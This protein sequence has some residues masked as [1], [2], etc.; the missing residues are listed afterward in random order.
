MSEADAVRIAAG[1]GDDG[2][3]LQRADAALGQALSGVVQAWLARHRDE[4]DV[5]LFFENYGR[6][7]RDGSS[8]SQAILDALGTRS[9][10]P[11]ADRD[12]VIDQAKQKAVSALAVGG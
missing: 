1:L 3:S 12:A 6:P 9:D 7:P 10:I 2:A 11:Q 8:W 5:D 4:W